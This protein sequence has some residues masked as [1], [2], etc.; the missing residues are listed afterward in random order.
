M[1]KII[2]RHRHAV[3]E[4]N[5]LDLGKIDRTHFT[6]DSKSFHERLDIECSVSGIDIL[7]H[8]LSCYRKFCIERD[9]RIS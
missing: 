7:H 9:L 6:V 4:N 5:L 1:Y 8:N 3:V 2:L